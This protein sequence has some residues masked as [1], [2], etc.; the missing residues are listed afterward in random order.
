[1]ALRWNVVTCLLAML[2]FTGCS[3]Q[4]P[5]TPLDAAKKQ[6]KTGQW[7]LAMDSCTQILQGDPNNG[8]ALS[9]RARA[10]GALGRYD[11]AVLDLTRWSE[12]NPN[13]PEPLYH[14]AIAYEKLGQQELADADNKAAKAVDPLH[15]RAYPF[16]LSS[17]RTTVATPSPR[18][19]EPDAA[20]AEQYT[21][22]EDSPNDDT[23]S[24]IGSTAGRNAAAQVAEESAREEAIWER[25]NQR[26]DLQTSSTN[27]D[28]DTRSL[29]GLD[30]NESAGAADGRSEGNVLDRVA[31]QLFV[32]NETPEIESTPD[33]VPPPTKPVISSALPTD[34]YGNPYVPGQRPLG[35]NPNAGFTNGSYA[36][37]GGSA[38][39]TSNFGPPYATQ[40]GFGPSNPVSTA[41]PA[42]L[43]GKL[44]TNAGVN[45]YGGALYPPA[46]TV[47]P[48]TVQPYQRTA[49]GPPRTDVRLPNNN[50]LAPSPTYRPGAPNV[51]RPPVSSALP[52]DY[53]QQIQQSRSATVP[54]YGP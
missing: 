9:I 47:A 7:N 37:P 22:E 21:F 15:K 28:F 19:D 27:S 4:A 41:L 40:P 50:T 1:M 31:D 12:L 30:R 36:P 11:D 6:F 39:P 3:Q 38:Y 34:P 48:G 8:E 51:V 29:L 16:E 45:Q 17:Q 53:L 46:A 44:G 33:F 20:D 14:R 49:Y 23:D 13:D 2:A 5:K 35:A 25:I 54:P 43:Q 26:L 18:S 24:F 52:R 32:P 42:Q 10:L